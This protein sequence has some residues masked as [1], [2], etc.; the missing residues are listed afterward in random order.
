MEYV[1]GAC[2]FVA[3]LAK[4]G[5]EYMA[6]VGF[7][8]SHCKERDTAKLGGRSVVTTECTIHQRGHLDCISDYAKSSRKPLGCRCGP[9][10]SLFR[11]STSL[12]EAA[13]HK[14]DLE[15]LNF[16]LN[17]KPKGNVTSALSA[18]AGAVANR[19]TTNS[20]ECFRTLSSAIQKV[21]E[22]RNF[23]AQAA[24]LAVG[25]AVATLALLPTDGSADSSAELV[26][27]CVVEIANMLF[28]VLPMGTVMTEAV[29]ESLL[30]HWG[31]SS[32]SSF[33][34]SLSSSLDFSSFNALL[35]SRDFSS[36]IASLSSC[37]RDFSSFIASLSSRD[38]STFPWIESISASI[39]SLF[40]AWCVSITAQYIGRNFIAKN[41]GNEIY[42]EYGQTPL[43][44]ASR[45]NAYQCVKTLIDQWAGRHEQKMWKSLI[46]SYW[47]LSDKNSGGNRAAMWSF[48][49]R[50]YDSCNDLCFQTHRWGVNTVDQC[51]HT[52]LHYAAEKNNV[53]CLN[54][55]LG[56]GANINATS[57]NGWTALH[58]AAQNGCAESVKKL[59]D[60]SSP[61]NIKNGDGNTALDLAIKNG[62]TECKKLLERYSPQPAGCL[63]L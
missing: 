18:A 36:F 50:F 19:Q 46:V 8:C 62:R 23:W 60:W 21:D 44:I 35:S 29:I 55:L 14:G 17:L 43:H 51:G 40:A 58:F 22:R 59:L 27:L 38:F 61:V 52:P 24:S 45:E 54:A 49:K 10:M 42:L 37:S 11:N 9:G 34:A 3:D 31:F 7:E 26:G 4:D 63:I 41:M 53:R 6:N 56:A 13:C 57:N 12:L 25:F 28:A 48:M 5:M 2:N 32:F 15:A 33:I 30:S 39:V 47:T 1:Y 16:R 20:I